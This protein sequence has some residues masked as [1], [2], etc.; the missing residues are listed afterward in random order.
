MADCILSVVIPTYNEAEN[1]PVL[2]GRILSC[3]SG[4]PHEIIVADDDSPDGTWRVAEELSRKHPEVRC[5][6]RTR[7]RGLYPA[8]AE[9]FSMAK[10]RYMAVLDADLQ[11]DESKLPVMLEC[12]RAQGLQLVVGSRHA[13]GGGI[14]GWNRARRLISR[15]ANGSCGALLRRGCSDLMSGFFLVER[16][17]YERAVGRLRPKGFKIL[18][19]LLQNLPADA[20]V[21]EVGYVFRPREQGHSKLNMRV[22]VDFAAGLGALLS[23]RIRGR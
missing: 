15:M 7:D 18:M 11:H 13:Q 6:R 20:R 2:V 5:L 17:A 10:G 12:A 4:I 16:Q 8:V 19:D 22:A 14:E 3:L 1:V 23:D 21:G 9:A